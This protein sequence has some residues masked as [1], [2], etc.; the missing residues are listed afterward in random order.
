M[1]NGMALWKRCGPGEAWRAAVLGTSVRELGNCGRASSLARVPSGTPVSSGSFYRKF[2]SMQLAFHSGSSVGGSLGVEGA[3]V[4]K[5]VTN[6]GSGELNFKAGKQVL[7]YGFRGSL[8]SLSRLGTLFS[9]KNCSRRLHCQAE[10][11]VSDVQTASQTSEAN[12]GNATLTSTSSPPSQSQG[13][14]P[15]NLVAGV[16]ITAAVLMMT[17]LGFMAKPSSNGGSVADLIKRGQLRSDRGTNFKNLNYDDPF[18]N[19]LVRMGDKNPIVK[20]CGKLFRLA[21]VTLTEE[22]V[23]KHQNRRIHAYKWRRPM[24]FLNEGE[25]VPEG[26]DPEEVRWIPSN[27]PFATTTN[28]IDEDMAQKNVYQTKGVPSR[29]RAEHEALRKRI[30]D[31][32]RGET[33][34]QL[35]NLENSG[36]QAWKPMDE[37]PESSGTVSGQEG[38]GQVN[39]KGGG[40][41]PRNLGVQGGPRNG[42]SDSRY[43]TID[44]SGE[45]QGSGRS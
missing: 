26:V 35:P 27:H 36:A 39:G 28:S 38:Q 34:F 12:S 19:P 13:G 30:L 22:K 44:F 3:A 15:V 29:V 40:N 7:N 25:P 43:R 17:L 45:E 14:L 31:T 8:T 37:T 24:V 2:S 42:I 16:G 41:S 32:A 18:N 23:L 21:P 20:M 9:R 33:E 10:A 4:A 5:C 6:L 1:L 11:R